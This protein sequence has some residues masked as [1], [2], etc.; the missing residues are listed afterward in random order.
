MVAVDT[1]VCALSGMGVP[2]LAVCLEGSG[3]ICCVG[4][5]RNQPIPTAE[6]SKK[7]RRKKVGVDRW[8]GTLIPAFAVGVAA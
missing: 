1:A 7:S 8:D 5:E 6:A 3:T 4:E 2:N